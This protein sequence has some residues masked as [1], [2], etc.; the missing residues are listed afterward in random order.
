MQKHYKTIFLLF[1]L[2]GTAHYFRAASPGARALKS[3]VIRMTSQPTVISNE[4]QLQISCSRAR[5]L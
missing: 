5:D 1:H 2:S 4:I 3:R